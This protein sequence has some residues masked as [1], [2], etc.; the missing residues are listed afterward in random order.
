MIMSIQHTV[1][2]FRRHHV[3]RHTNLECKSANNAGLNYSWDLLRLWPIKSIWVWDD[4][5]TWLQRSRGLIRVRYGVTNLHKKWGAFLQ[6]EKRKVVGNEQVGQQLT[7]ARRT[8]CTRD[9]SAVQCSAV[10]CSAVQCSAVQCSAVQCSLLYQQSAAYTYLSQMQSTTSTWTQLQQW[11][12]SVHICDNH[13]PVPIRTLAETTHTWNHARS[14][15]R[16]KSHWSGLNSW[17]Q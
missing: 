17:G 12:C 9:I 15:H 13:S 16:I 14:E 2:A 10:Q 5:D 6:V 8:V 4:Q 11:H 3:N 7:A 1:C